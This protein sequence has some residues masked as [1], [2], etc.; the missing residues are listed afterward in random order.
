MR[1]QR[2]IEALVQAIEKAGT[3][4]AAPVA[5]ALEHVTL[6]R[7]GQKGFMRGSDHQFQQAL[8][9]G[10]MDHQ[11]E[12]GVAFDVEGSSYGFRVIKSLTPEAAQLP[13][14][15]QMQRD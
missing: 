9:V 13:T 6:A 7:F 5:R 12:P 3:V 8:V 15:C 4:D 11:G 14:S 10:Q 1:M 2:M